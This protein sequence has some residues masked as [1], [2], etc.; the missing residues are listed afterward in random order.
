MNKHLGSLVKA[1]AVLLGVPVA[2]GLILTVI[3]KL[4][5]DVNAYAD[6]LSE[7]SPKVERLLTGAEYLE[8]HWHTEC[9]GT[10]DHVPQYDGDRTCRAIRDMI[11]VTPSSAARCRPGNRR[12]RSWA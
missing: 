9:H 6:A 1:T 2:L 4:G 7:A 12:P 8:H 5:D 10:A 11:V 3:G